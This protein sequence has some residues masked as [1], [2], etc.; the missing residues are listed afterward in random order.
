MSNYG[1]GISITQEHRN[2]ADFWSRFCGVPASLSKG[3]RR[4]L[5]HPV[6][7]LSFG[8]IEGHIGLAE[9]EIAILVQGA[10][11]RPLDRK[12]VRTGDRKS[13]RLNSSHLGISYAV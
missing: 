13:T 5:R 4:R 12:N 3:R 6:A 8:T 10:A 2:R 7:P 9:K 1:A 11:G